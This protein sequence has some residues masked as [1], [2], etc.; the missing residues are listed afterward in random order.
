MGIQQVEK[1][2][3]KG[4][5]KGDWDKIE[6]ASLTESGKRRK[7]TLNGSRRKGGGPSRRR[8]SPVHP[9]G[10]GSEL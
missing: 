3:I 1:W 10:R 7:E 6:S 2:L 5:N 4:G 9:G 8:S